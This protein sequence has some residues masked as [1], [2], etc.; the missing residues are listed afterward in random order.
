MLLEPTDD[1][2]SDFIM[3]SLLTD[4]GR[5]LLTDEGRSLLID[6]GSLFIEE[7]ERLPPY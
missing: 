4:G 6:T 7:D 3:G 5:S 1:T 2:G